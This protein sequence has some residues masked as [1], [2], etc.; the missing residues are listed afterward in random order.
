MGSEMS[1][2]MHSCASGRGYLGTLLFCSLP[3]PVLYP[4]MALRDCAA[5]PLPLPLNALP[6]LPHACW[7]S[8]SGVSQ[9]VFAP[10]CPELPAAALPYCTVEV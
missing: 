10:S 9:A 2:A 3:T 1:E 7:S 6:G 5:P 4:S 8:S